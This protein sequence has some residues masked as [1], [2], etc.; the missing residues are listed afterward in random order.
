MLAQS[1]FFLDKN[2]SGKK[3]ILRKLER[4]DL[5]TSITWFKDPAINKFLSHNFKKLTIDEEFQ[6]FNSIQLSNRDMVFAIIAKDKDKY[7][8]NCGLHK[9]DWSGKT[10]EL[11]IVIGNK[12][13][14]DKGY[15]SDVINSITDFAINKLNLLNIHLNVYEY[16]NRAIKAYTKCGFKL[17]KILKKNHFYNNKYWDTFI[18][19][20]R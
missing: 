5:E 11:G 1:F 10:C 9:I 7:I 8:G 14:W 18:M 19:E 20:Y 15:G 3:I 17:I 12:E 13:Y 4:C 6:W 2:I 16:N